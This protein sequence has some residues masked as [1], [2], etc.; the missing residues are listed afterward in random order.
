MSAVD[1]AV[2]RMALLTHHRLAVEAVALCLESSSDAVHARGIE[3]AKAL[4][5]AGFSVDREV[6]AEI[7]RRGWITPEHAWLPPSAR[8]KRPGGDAA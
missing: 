3:Y 8:Q 4:D 1:R 7:E 6:D 5:E 2:Y